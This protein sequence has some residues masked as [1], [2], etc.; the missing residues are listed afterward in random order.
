MTIAAQAKTE[1]RVMKLTVSLIPF[2][3][4]FTDI[5]IRIDAGSEKML[6]RDQLFIIISSSS[7]HMGRSSFRL[8]RNIVVNGGK[9]EL[10]VECME[11]AVHPTLLHA[12]DVFILHY[13]L[14]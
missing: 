9:P 6:F 3:H 4:I 14:T 12:T 8:Y 13:H 1:I 5:C 7:S 11:T 2:L 10:F